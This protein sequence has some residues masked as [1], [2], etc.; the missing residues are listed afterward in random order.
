MAIGGGRSSGGDGIADQGAI[1]SQH[2]GLSPPG[3]IS[4]SSRG[5]ITFESVG[6]MICNQVIRRAHLARSRSRVSVWPRA[7]ARARRACAR[8]AVEGQKKAVESQRKA[9]GRRM[10]GS[11]KAHGRCMEGAWKA[12]GRRMEGAW[13]AHGRRGVPRGLPSP[14]VRARCC[15]RQR[16]QRSGWTS[17]PIFRAP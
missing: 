9:H 14:N 13:K 5:K 10:E 3:E 7:T 11:W 12:H 2:D 16:W 6:V 17:P 8:I 4:A 15:A 1:G